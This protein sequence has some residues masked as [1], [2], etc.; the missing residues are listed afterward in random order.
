MS[1]LG[2]VEGIIVDRAFLDDRANQALEIST[3]DE[4]REAG[5]RVPE[6]LPALLAAIA[7]TRSQDVAPALIAGVLSL[8]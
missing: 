3:L 4:L 1:D 5:W 2:L 8:P 6:Q 7:M